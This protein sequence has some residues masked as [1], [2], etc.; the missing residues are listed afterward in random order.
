MGR[1]ITLISHQFSVVV[2]SMEKG[3][4]DQGYDVTLLKDDINAIKS[5]NDVTDAY[6]LYI[7]D[8]ILGDMNGVKS[9]FLLCDTFKDLR[10][11][12]ILIGSANTHKEFI[13]TVPALGD[14]EWIDRPV[15]MN[16]LIKELEKEAGR[17]DRNREK[18][19]ILII[20]DDPSYARMIMVWLQENYAI[21]AVSDGMQG[22]SWL[23]RNLVDLILLDYEMP[24]VD[25]PKILEMLRMHSD[26]SS[27][28]VMFLTGIG[29]KESIARVMK[30]KPQGY[31]LKSTTNEEL[32][33]T[34][35]EFF[36]KQ[37]NSIS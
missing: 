5:L 17:A 31:I 29:T 16:V 23:A 8:S 9:L 13:D 6:V 4:G 24:V 30:L 18:K 33:K 7:Q 15:D 36:Q 14:Y 37:S 28:P 3:L 35:D 27:I 1:K 34:L 12:M 22:I 19:R 11:N 2:K 21:D 25:G 32:N 20:D 10:R 26:T